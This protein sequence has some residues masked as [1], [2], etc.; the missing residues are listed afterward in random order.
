ML[1]PPDIALLCSSRQ[2]PVW[3]YLERWAAAYPGHVQLAERYQQLAPAAILFLVSCSELISAAQRQSFGLVLT[4]HASAL[5]EGRG[6]S[7]H[8][9]Q[10]LEGKNSLT[11]SLID[12]VEP[13][14]SGN[15]WLQQQIELDGSELYDEINTRLFTAEIALIDQFCA[16]HSQL[17]SRPQATAAGSYFPKRSAAD[18][19]LDPDLSLRA[20]FN[21]LRVCDPE[22]FPAYVELNGQKYLVKIEKAN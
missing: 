14:D 20:Q 6:W 15:I 9:W 13:V 1:K 18:S 12:A 21:L 11:L 7:P 2:H 8:I 16:Q 4:L 3:P 17:K 5:P 19:R 22:R 10:I